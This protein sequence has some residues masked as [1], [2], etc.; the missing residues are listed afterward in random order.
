M[1]FDICTTLSRCSC[2]QQFE[3]EQNKTSE[4]KKKY[5]T[6]HL[7]NGTKTNTPKTKKDQNKH[8]ENQVKKEHSMKEDKTKPKSNT[9]KKNINNIFP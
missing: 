7:E 1:E 3:M 5:T 6:K 9:Q 4:K 2:I 8:Y